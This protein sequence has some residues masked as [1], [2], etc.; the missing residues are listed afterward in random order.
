MQV[1]EGLDGDQ[2]LKASLFLLKWVEFY[3]EGDKPFAFCSRIV[4]AWRKKIKEASGRKLYLLSKGSDTII[5]HNSFAFFLRI[6]FHKQIDKL[7]VECSAPN[8]R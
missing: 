4:S 6:A 7:L 3:E 8:S 5:R 2:K 1:C